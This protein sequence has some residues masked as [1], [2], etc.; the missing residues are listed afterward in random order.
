[1]KRVVALDPGGTTGVRTWTDHDEVS[2]LEGDVWEDY[3]LGP[4]EHHEE[5]YDFLKNNMHYIWTENAGEMIIVYETFEFRRGDGHR[6]G[7]NLMSREYIGVVKLF[8]QTYGIPV[9][10]YTAGTG[11]GFIPDKAVNGMEA[12]AKLKVMGL[13][14]P[15]KKHSNDATR[16][17]IYYLVNVLGRKDLIACWKDLM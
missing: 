10:G 16:H 12:N 1:M 13:Y 8:H 6:E 17:L 7:I 5:L 9:V 14:L 3:H 2:G 11:K 4:H 15:G